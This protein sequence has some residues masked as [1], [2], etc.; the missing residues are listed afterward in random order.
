MS[1]KTLHARISAVCPIHGVNAN[2]IIAFKDEATQQQ[3]DEAQAIADAWDFES[4]TREELAAAAAK[5]RLVEIDIA[6]VRAIREYIAAKPDAPKE[7]KDREAEAAV[8]RGKL[9]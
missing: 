2:R 1:L 6:S 8:E 7:L 9:E 4:G 5:A 3:R